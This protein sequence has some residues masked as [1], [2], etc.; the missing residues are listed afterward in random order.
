MLS[1]YITVNIRKAISFLATR[2]GISQNMAVHRAASLVKPI[3]KRSAPP[4]FI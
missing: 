4:H 2:L 1:K 3:N